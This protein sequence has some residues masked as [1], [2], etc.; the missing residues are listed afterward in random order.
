MLQQRVNK[1]PS[2]RRTR[3]PKPTSS[4]E[5]RK[6]LGSFII[7]FGH[8]MPRACSACRRNGTDCKVHVRSGRC[9]ECHMRGSTCDVRIT[10]SE[11]DRLR[12]ERERLLREIEAS[13][14][15]QEAAVAAQVEARRQMDEAF[16]NE[17]KLRQEML[18]LESEAEEAI[19]VED[20]RL[21]PQDPEPVGN[22]ILEPTEPAAGLALS[23]FTWSAGDGLADQFWAASPSAPWVLQDSASTG[24]PVS[25]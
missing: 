7:A 19:A 18:R 9:G 1:N 20:A 22:E 13:R 11:W 25:G 4:T 24:R 21:Y 16:Q 3:P 23:P 5:D 8:K 2:K 10:K 12:S 14:Q 15:A 6:A 17:M